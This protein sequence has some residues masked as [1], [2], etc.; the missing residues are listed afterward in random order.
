MEE[1][2]DIVPR[3]VAFCAHAT[4]ERDSSHGEAHMTQVRRNAMTILDALI[5]AGE[6]PDVLQTPE[7]RR[8]VQAAAQFHD[9]A[10]H[11]YVDDPSQCG[12]EPELRTYFSHDTAALIVR[13]MEAVS[14]SKERRLRH[15]LALDQPHSFVESLGDVGA[16]V[17]DIVSDADKLEAIGTVGA[18]RCMAY[19]RE[20]IRRTERREATEAE[21]VAYLVVHAEEKLL[22]L[23]CHN[24]IRTSVGRAMA[25]PLHQQMLEMLCATLGDDH[26]ARDQ[27]C[28][29][30]KIKTNLID[31]GAVVDGVSL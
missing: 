22:F 5:D 3:L 21:V 13:I 26:A 12:L 28:A 4:K 10:D 24:Y 2:D 7:T 29:R 23:L 17:R 16:L 30:F 14:Y 1:D 20:C 6:S 19:A 9:I 18:E 8:M 11:K 31:M 27:L 25:A 15:E